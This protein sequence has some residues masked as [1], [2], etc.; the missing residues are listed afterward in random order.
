MVGDTR[1]ILLAGQVATIGEGV[2]NAPRV[3]Q[4]RASDVCCIKERCA[5]W[6]DGECAIPEAA[7]NTRHLGN[8]G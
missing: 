1:P 5:W 2:G 3:L 6:G 4:S 8:R 7:R